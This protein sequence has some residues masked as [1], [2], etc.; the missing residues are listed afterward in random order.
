MDVVLTVSAIVAILAVFGG[1]AILFGKLL[2]EVK[3]INKV[4][5]INA[6][7]FSEYRKTVRED[8]GE[9]QEKIGN[10][11]TRITVLEQK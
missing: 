11:E 3:A 10:H 2:A 8:I 6:I 7:D 9:L 1:F 5:K 4:L